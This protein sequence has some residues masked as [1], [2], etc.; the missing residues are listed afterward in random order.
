MGPDPKQDRP[1]IVD[2]TLYDKGFLEFSKDSNQY[3]NSVVELLKEQYPEEFEMLKLLAEGNYEEFTYFVSADPRMSQHVIGYGLVEEG[4][5]AHFFK[6]GVVKKYFESLEKSPKLLTQEARRD[7][8]SRRINM[9]ESQLRRLISTVFSVAFHPNERKAKLI[10]KIATQRR[11]S[12]GNY[13]FEDL[14][15]DGTCPLFLLD[16]V[17]AI[18][19]N[20]DKFQNILQ[21]EK[22]SFEHHS[23]VLN[24]ARRFPSHAKDISEE[25]F[26]KA[27]V[28][29]SELERVLKP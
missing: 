12:L 19:A 26:Q 6:V 27:R 9:V 13:R 1:L 4:Q 3:V 10:A 29:L 16:L 24:E 22:A 17:E 23:Q 28:S 7:E 5:A 21:M 20:W 15:S 18:R 2:R 14:L 8:L 11:E 25:E